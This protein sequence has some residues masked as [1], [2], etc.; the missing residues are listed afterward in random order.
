M[1][2]IGL[3]NLEQNYIKTVILLKKKKMTLLVHETSVQRRCYRWIYDN[4][5]NV[6]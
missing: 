6:V 1:V 4:I 3:T 2:F 5:I